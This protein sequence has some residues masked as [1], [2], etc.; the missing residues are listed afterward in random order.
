M[1]DDDDPVTIAQ[2]A[3][4]A[5]RERDEAERAAG[6]VLDA[7]ATAAIE[8]AL[9]LAPEVVAAA[10][11]PS[12]ERVIDVEVSSLSELNFIRKRVNAALTV[13]EWLPEVAVWVWQA[14]VNKRPPLS[15]RG[16]AL[17]FELRMEQ[18]TSGR[19]S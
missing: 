10:D 15:E 17:G 2:R 6:R 18:G 8:Q 11:G 3:Q 9:S 14:E 13:S 1:T 4:T 5:R 19:S 12:A 16:R 7:T